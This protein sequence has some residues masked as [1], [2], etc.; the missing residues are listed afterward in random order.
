VDSVCQLLVRSQLLPA[1]DVRALQQRWRNEMPA[2]A[3]DLGRFRQWL[4][5]QSYVTDYQARL[6]FRGLADNFFINQYKILDR[7][8]EGRM[9]GVYLAVHPLGPVVAIKLLP[10][11]KARNLW[12]AARFRR[13]ARLALRLRH[14]HVVRAFHMGETKGLPFLVM[15]YLQGD[16]LKEILQRRGKLPIPEAIRV[17]YQAL[18]GLQHLHDQQMIH[19]DLKPANLMVV[20]RPAAGQPDNTLQ[21]SV[22]IVDIGFARSLVREDESETEAPVDAT[23]EDTLLGTP[24]YL[25]PE[26][27]C[28]AHKA[29]IR[30]DIYSL[31]CVLYET[32]AGQPPFHDTNLN[33]QLIRHATEA[34]RPLQEFQAELPAGLQEVARVLLAKSPEE[35]YQ[36]PAAA[37]VALQGFLSE[38]PEDPCVPEADPRM[39]QYLAWLDTT[40][41]QAASAAPSTAPDQTTRVSPFR[42]LLRA[43]SRDPNSRS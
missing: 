1:A 9:A 24:D 15:E 30:A 25:A 17:V 42:R 37:A 4:V 43:L 19:R 26:Q 28:D 23:G 2:G 35:R 6:L 3:G 33:R 32:L 36:T 12:M 5:A 40:D 34:P 7:I 13:E 22:K 27:A 41:R 21:A 16:T 20:P 8:N 14:P 18:L 10:A 38:Q 39:Q 31:G 11:G 29:D